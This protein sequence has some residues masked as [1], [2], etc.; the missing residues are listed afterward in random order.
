MREAATRLLPSD[1]RARLLAALALAFGFASVR[2]V[3]L[4]PVIATLALGVMLAAGEPLRTLRRLR[5][6]A[7]LALA[8]VAILPLV[9][10]ATILWEVG[11]VRVRAEGLE[12]GLLI[13]GRLV[14][15]VAVTLAL[16]A[17]VSP[18]RLAAALRGVGVPA[19]MADLALLTL[20]YFEEL[21][22]EIARVRLARRLR[23]GRDGWRSVGEHG[24]MLAALVIRSQ[25]RSER[26][27]A[28]MRLRG[29]DAIATPPPALDG[30][31]RV[32]TALA[33]AIG[34]AVF[35]LGRSL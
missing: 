33:A 31:D 35:V 7:L 19:A 1:P 11:P 26:I 22:G 32:V 12:A 24:L 17:S 5:G 29:Y 9:S 15:I 28:A 13:G 6:P 23:G 10:G 27:W 16:L 2:D 4:V 25:R 8:F 14:S 3:A 30:R 34:I 21:R 20:R 18:L